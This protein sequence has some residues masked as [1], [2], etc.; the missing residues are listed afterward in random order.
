MYLVLGDA[1]ADWRSS[2]RELMVKLSNAPSRLYHLSRPGPGRGLTA[3]T[4]SPT[5]LAAE[6]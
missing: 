5:K 2:T 1:V 4:G 3:A 6:L